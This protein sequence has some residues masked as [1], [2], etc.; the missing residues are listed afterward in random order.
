MSMDLI[1]AAQEVL[2][3]AGSDRLKVD[4]WFGRETSDAVHRAL[5][6]GAVVLMPRDQMHRVLA[7]VRITDAPPVEAPRAPARGVFDSTSEARLIGVHPDLVAVARDAREHLMFDVI[8]GV[9]TLDRQRELFARGASKTLNSRHL[10]GHAI[11]LW[12]VDPATGRRAVADNA[13]LW[14]LLTPIAAAMKAAARVRDVAMEW[15][16]DW[17]W[18]APHFQ[19][20]RLK[21]RG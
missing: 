11:D 3:A 13:L 5:A 1:R 4:G 9:R 18:D 17:G 2:R 19:L 8:E 21:Y 12:P 20:N 10:T 15:G 6:A 7:P 14:R 16:G